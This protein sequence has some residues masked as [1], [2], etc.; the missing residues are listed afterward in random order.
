[1]CG[2]ASIYVRKRTDNRTD[3]D[4]C[5]QC[6]SI[7]KLAGGTSNMVIHMKLHHPLLLPGS[8]TGNKQKADTFVCISRYTGTSY[9]IKY[10]YAYRY[11][12]CT[13]TQL[14]NQTNHY[15]TRDR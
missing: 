4:V 7:I 9:P 14:Y 13:S 8:L 12:F 3:A 15:I 5:K 2:N 10:W 11:V 6:N 1:M